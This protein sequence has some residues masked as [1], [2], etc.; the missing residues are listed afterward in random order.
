MAGLAGK[1][2]GYCICGSHCS[3]D[4]VFPQIERLIRARATVYPVLSDPA[5]TV[6]TRFG[7]G[8]QRL[9]TLENIT[10]NKPIISLVE[11]EPL[12][13]SKLFDIAVVA[14]CTGNTLAKLANSFTDSAVL[15]AVKAT[16]RNGRP[17]V[18]A[19]ST[20]DA[21]SGNAKNIGLLLDKRNVYFVP[22]G[23]D[24]PEAKPT[25]CV[26]DFDL[27]LPAIEAALEGRQLQPVLIERTR[28]AVK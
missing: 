4:E 28:R 17:I 10:G 18:V 9:D 24:N 19:I 20:N 6:T 5:A 21:L 16:L 23:Q 2:I 13:P 12:G 1:K 3:Y 22:F 26:A 15:M 27:I 14:P 8:E 11:A 7:T 25:S